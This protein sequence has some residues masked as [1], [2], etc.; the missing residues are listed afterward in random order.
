MPNR[1]SLGLH[2]V[3]PILC[4]LPPSKWSPLG[5]SNMYFNAKSEFFLNH[6]FN[7]LDYCYVETLLSL[8]PKSDTTI[9]PAT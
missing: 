6:T 1:W 2:P 7:T 3:N 8:S 5:V 4:S 9:V